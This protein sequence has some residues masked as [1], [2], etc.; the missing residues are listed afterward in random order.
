MLIHKA[1]KFRI[2]P[3]AEQKVLIHKTIGCCRFVF[4]FALAAQRKEE[5]YWHITQEMYQSGQLLS[6]EW[7]SKWFCSNTAKLGLPQLKKH[8]T[9]LK[10]V[11]SIALQASIEHLGD[12]YNRYYKKQSGKPAFKS[13]KKVIQSYTTK[14]TNGNIKIIGNKIQLPKLGM[15]KFAKSREVE[16]RILNATIRRNSSGTYFVSLLTENEVHPFPKTHTEVG[17][18]VGLKDFAVLSNGEVFRNPKFF[19]TA[20][21]KLA[22]AQRKLSRRKRGGSNWHK[23]RIKVARIH[24][25]IANARKDFLDKTSTHI[26]K[27]HD[28]IAI[29]DLHITN[30]LK[31]GKLSKAIQDASWAMFRSMLTY[32]SQWYG[33]VMVTVAHT[34]AS[35]QTCSSCGNKNI[36]V[37]N[38][39]IREWTCSACG[40]LHNR[41]FNASLNILSEGNRILSV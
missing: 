41:D 32:K 1:F 31:N 33:R 22:K 40:I 7:R 21:R 29:E 37:K 23:Q 34:F 26:V 24:E 14:E 2:Y 30:M 4:N 19:R 8:Y 20:E 17:I 38:L 10:E 25:Y 35:S 9:W 18:D 3:T 27:N 39:S 16:G 28:R 15:V 36:E 5:Q 11:D 6:N 13:K 12:A